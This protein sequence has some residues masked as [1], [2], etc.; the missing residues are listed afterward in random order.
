[1]KKNH[2]LL[3]SALI[4]P[5]FYPQLSHARISL[6]FSTTFECPPQDQSTPGWVNCDG[7]SKAGDNSTDSGKL[8]EITSS[9]TFEGGGGGLGHRYWIG[10]GSNNNSGG[11]NFDFTAPQSEVYV[12]WYVRW[13]KGLDLDD[14]QKVLYSIGAGTPLQVYFDLGD[15]PHA[16]RVV[17]AGNPS[18]VQGWG[19]FELNGNSNASD[20]EWHCFEVHFKNNP[21]ATDVAEW[22]IDGVKRLHFSDLDYAG[23][24]GGFGLPANQRVDNPSGDFFNDTDDIVIRTTGPIGCIPQTA[25]PPSPPSSP[26]GLRV[27]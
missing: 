19:W 13:Q 3:L 22:W 2:F 25:H 6:P 7:L 12:R 9:A 24:M 18:T 14:S 5:L 26:K 1:M 8:S 20:E 23:D 16:L 11:I 17:L 4:I 10:P 15:N 21:G 27:R